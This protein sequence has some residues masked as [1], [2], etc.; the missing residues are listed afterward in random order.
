[1]EQSG[2]QITVEITP[3][4]AVEFLTKL[5]TNED[6][7]RERFENDTQ[8]LLAEYGITVPQALL[9][10]SVTAPP[11][12]TLVEALTHLERATVPQVPFIPVAR[13]MP[14]PFGPVPFAPGSCAYAI[15]FLALNEASK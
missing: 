3:D 4:Q 15:V 5:A 14:V 8:A 1:M 7:V 10:E 6:S 13:P 2:E 9:P 12:S 11:V